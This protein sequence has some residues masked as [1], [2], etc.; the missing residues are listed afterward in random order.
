MNQII[1]NT[2]KAEYETTD[3]S[4][5]DIAAKYSVTVKELKGSNRWKKNLLAPK[6]KAEKKA[7]IPT[8]IDI[9]ANT[10][11]IA[12]D[13]LLL[14]SD[15]DPDSHMDAKVVREM[16]DEL[17]TDLILQAS[18]EVQKG[19]IPELPTELKDGFEGLRRL[20]TALQEQAHTLI[21]KVGSAIESIDE[22]DTKALRDLA[23]I[24]TTIRDSYFNSKNTMVSIINGDVTQN[25]NTQNN[26]LSMIAEV[27]SDC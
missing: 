22:T 6:T 11:I 13:D 16:T 9:L 23:A 5:D 26:L 21:K 14:V 27:E 19:N 24:H 8:H 25:N 18:Q 20:D 4:L 2:I 12:N 17:K 3:L 10:D 7:H 1:L 15:P